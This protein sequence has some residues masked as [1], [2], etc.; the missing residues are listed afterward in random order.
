MVIILFRLLQLEIKA[1]ILLRLV[2]EWYR[3][4]RN[5]SQSEVKVAGTET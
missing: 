3:I 4:A 1:Q 2:W 5:R